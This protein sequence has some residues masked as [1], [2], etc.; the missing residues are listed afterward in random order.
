MRTLRLLLIAPLAAILGLPSIA[1]AQ[2][3][4]AVPSTLL[5]STVSEHVG[6]RDADRAA[7]RAALA[8]AQV[9]QLAAT[10]GIDLDRA[11]QMV[12]TLGGP[13]LVPAADAARAVNDSLVGGQSTI[14]ISTTT[15]I[16]ALLILLLIIVA[17]D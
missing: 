6:A 13:E 5:H 2:E 12:D 14:V 15:V 7:I 4:H 1:S 9:R 8:H 3:R 10:A 17:V 16:I 11:A